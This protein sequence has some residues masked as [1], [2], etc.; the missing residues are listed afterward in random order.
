MLSTMQIKFEFEINLFMTSVATND[1]SKLA[2]C[3][4]QQQRRLNFRSNFVQQ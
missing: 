1:E 2:F 3:L 4:K